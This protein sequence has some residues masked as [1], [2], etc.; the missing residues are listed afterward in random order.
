MMRA[1]PRIKEVYDIGPRQVTVTGKRPCIYL[2]KE[3][4]FLIG[5][6][7]LLKIKVLEES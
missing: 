3:F 6:K 7:V 1:S 5:R 2:P 4:S